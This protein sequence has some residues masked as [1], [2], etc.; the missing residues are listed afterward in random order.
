MAG[1]LGTQTLLSSSG[2]GANAEDHTTITLKNGTVVTG[3]F[4]QNGG[5]LVLTSFN[6]K[7]GVV[8]QLE[9]I[10]SIGGRMSPPNLIALDSGGFS[11]ILNAPV[12][13]F[14]DDG[15]LTRFEFDEDG[16]AVGTSEVLASGWIDDVTA[17]KTSNGVF[18]T[19]RDRDA[20]A[21]IEYVGKFYDKAGD[22]LKT[23]DFTTNANMFGFAHPEPQAT[24]L[25]N[26]NLAVVWQKT[27]LDG[28]FLQIFR[29]NGSKVGSET[30]LSD[31]PLNSQVKVIETHPDGG[32]ITA[33]APTTEV[34]GSFTTVGPIEIQRYNNKGEK[35]GA[36]ITFD[37]DSD[38]TSGIGFGNDFDVAFTKD[39]LIAIAWTGADSSTSNGTDVHFAML[40]ASGTVIVGPQAADIT[41]ND[42]Q[43]DV[44]FTSLKNGSLFLTFKDDATEQLSH[45]ASIQGRFV[46][47]PDFLWEGNKQNNTHSGTDGDDVL[48]GLNGNDTLK[49]GKG[50]DY[51]NGGKG[52]DKIFGGN[53]ADDLE[54]EDGDDFVSGGAG[55]DLLTGGTGDDVLRGG[56]GDDIAYGGLGNDT[57]R[58]DR[59]SDMLYGEAG[60]D[61]LVGGT[62][63]SMLYGGDGKDTLKGGI[64]NDTLMGEDG[65]DTLTGN[66][67]NDTL[68]GGTGKDSLKGGIGF[69]VL[70]GGDDNDKLFG[71]D[72]DDALYS[73]DGDDVE[74]GGDGNDQL[75][76]SEGDD[77]MTGGAGADRFIF[78]NADFGHDVIT[79][80][81]FGVD[82]LDMGTTARG[83]DF[84]G[85]DIL[86]KQLSAGVRFKVD[87]DNWVL[88]KGAEL[89]DFQ[90]GDYIIE[91][92]F[93]LF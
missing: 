4:S 30:S 59:G 89:A 41:L 76:D 80:F 16:A 13:Y 31:I 21:E 50:Q 74:F 55:N 65:N 69:D 87:A 53:F 48:L 46:V 49:G 27:G 92:P 18:I 79:D 90:T 17:T 75:Y 44:E 3:Y 43:L 77:K 20:D 51:I 47:E 45:V 38:G 39:G 78:S 91:D 36:K 85:G 88:V 11:V 63:D 35:V 29:P 37:T 25:S 19:Y 26:G 70:R 71:E 82:T 34:P 2:L 60:N 54:G 93:A 22:L 62:K 67:G 84:S 12:G 81:Q 10:G 5:P 14:A 9:T 64:G 1:F 56:G 23:F 32:F 42:D 52:N 28:S 33:H 8:T 68:D 86:V 7:T 57:L 66:G 40:T 6:P 83:L 73:G 58:G 61:K 72:G 15:R 24:L